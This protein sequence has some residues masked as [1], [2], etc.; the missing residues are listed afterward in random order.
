MAAVAMLLVAFFMVI[1]SSYAWFTLSTAPEVTGIY[2]AVG[3]NGNLEIALY[4]G[5]DNIGSNVGDSNLGAIEKNK[6][7]GNIV[8]LSNEGYGLNNIALYPS[9][10]ALDNGS[11]LAGGGILGTPTCGNDGRIKSVNADGVAGIYNITTKN[12]DRNSTAKGVRAIGTVSSMSQQQLDW[13]NAVSKVSS[14]LNSARVTAETSLTANGQALIDII[15]GSLDEEK[16]S[17]DI[18]AVGNMLTALAGTPATQGTAAVLG[19]ADHLEEAMKYYLI[20]AAAAA[21]PNKSDTE[22]V[23]IKNAI[24]N[25]CDDGSFPDLSADFV[26]GETGVT[27]TV[28]DALKTVYNSYLKI[29][30]DI[31]AAVTAYNDVD[32]KE[33]A[34]QD[35]AVAILGHLVVVNNVI[36]NGT[37]KSNIIMSDK[38]AVSNLA[39]SIIAEG[40]V[41][42]EIP[43]ATAENAESGLFFNIAQLTNNMNAS[44]R[45]DVTAMGITVSDMPISIKTTVA[46]ADKYILGGAKLPLPQPD[47]REGAVDE[48]LSNFYGYAID[49]AFR[50]NAAS[51]NLM[52]QTTPANRIYSENGVSETMGKGS[53]MTFNVTDTKFT[54][55]NILNLMGHIRIVFT[56]ANGKVIAAARLDTNN[57]VETT[58]TSAT[59]Q[60]KLCEYTLTTL[61]R[62]GAA[63]TGT[64]TIQIISFGEIKTV[65]EKGQMELCALTQNQ[66]TAISAYVYLDGETVESRD[67]GTEDLSMTGTL[68]LQFSS[69]ATLKAMPYADLQGQTETTTTSTT[70]ADNG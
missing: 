58:G 52:L 28:P 65:N 30:S 22:F 20:A 68:N 69:D 29:K 23:A 55:D 46:D 24:I 31:D 48:K 9:V 36:V 56:D 63:G 47:P 50:T 2:T 26:V 42:V 44:F 6:T 27:V 57:N 54:V 16:T 8:D 25:D 38:D 21:V 66:Q 12:F 41:I 33:A 19:V 64:E 13:G 51:S 45:A 7:W 34:T 39:G 60:V 49:L 5:N 43:K 4:T 18:T 3:A 1:S 35:E 37:P 15:L 70:T 40:A 10:L 61:D 11:L 14:S 67:V 59:A 17:F 32:N 53:T 62:D